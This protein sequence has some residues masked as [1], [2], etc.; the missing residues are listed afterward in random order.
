MTSADNATHGKCTQ[1]CTEYMTDAHTPYGVH[2]ASAYTRQAHMRGTCNDRSYGVDT[3]YTYK[4]EYN[5]LG[6]QHGR[7]ELTMEYFVDRNADSVNRELLELQAL[8]R[9]LGR[10]VPLTGRDQV[11]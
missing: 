4:T 8:D 10:G 11:S 3:R 6:G 1:H 2:M 7:K 9:G 5:V